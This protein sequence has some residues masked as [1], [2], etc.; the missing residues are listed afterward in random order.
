MRDPLRRLD[1]AFA[2]F[3]HRVKFG[4]TPGYPRFRSRRGYV[5]VSAAE[6]FAPD[7]WL[8]PTP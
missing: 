6:G 8:A 4:D 7:P 5:A 3:F 1:R 2:A